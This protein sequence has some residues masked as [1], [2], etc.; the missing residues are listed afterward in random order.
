MSYVR[1]IGKDNGIPK[2]QA[3]LETAKANL[4]SLTE[5]HGKP[6]AYEEEL[7]ATRRRFEE[8]TQMVGDE[9][10]EDKQRDPLPLF[11]FAQAIN[12][13][14]GSHQPLVSYARTI[15]DTSGSL[16]TKWAADETEDDDEDLE[17][18]LSYDDDPSDGPGDGV[19]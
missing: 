9:V 10:N 2:T 5:D 8:L 3:T 4:A 1:K 6:F 11:K 17:L 19:A 14:T 18:A 7:Q 12:K 13:Q 15:A 16:M